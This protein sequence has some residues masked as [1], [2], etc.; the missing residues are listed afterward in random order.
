MRH[1]ETSGAATDDRFGER[2]TG[3]ALAL[4]LRL[5]D[6]PPGLLET[7]SILDRL[8][9]KARSGFMVRQLNR[10]ISPE[11]YILVAD[12]D[13]AVAELVSRIKGGGSTSGD[14]TQLLDIAARHSSTPEAAVAALHALRGSK[15]GNWCS[16]TTADTLAKHS[17]PAVLG[18]LADLVGANPHLYR[19]LCDRGPHAE[20]LHQRLHDSHMK[21][22]D[23]LCGDTR[24]AGMKETPTAS[25]S[26]HRASRPRA[27]G[28]VRLWSQDALETMSQLLAARTA[29]EDLA[30][31][32]EN[33][34]TQL[35]RWQATLARA[36]H[37]PAVTVT[38]LLTDPL[39]EHR[40][41]SSAGPHQHTTTLR[42][43]DAALAALHP[44]SEPEG[45]WLNANQLRAQVYADLAFLLAVDGAQANDAL[46]IWEQMA[47]HDRQARRVPLAQLSHS[48]RQRVWAAAWGG[49]AASDLNPDRPWPAWCPWPKDETLLALEAASLSHGLPHPNPSGWLAEQLACRLDDS[50]ALDDAYR[51][52]LTLSATWSGN[53]GHLLD[54]C[55]AAVRR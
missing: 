28:T 51:Q 25:M 20:L 53:L 3:D 41:S 14:L 30:T 16:D 42:G 22:Q 37:D 35:R 1:T 6:E 23:F 47:E 38:E 18:A 12:A 7:V 8:E 13:E 50:S 15:F 33:T 10:M 34:Y 2:L 52:T 46:P 29:T 9:G 17:D 26:W 32:G 24:G 45:E 55:A 43:G 27:G 48:S 40:S 11:N 54:A 4:H 31:R 5:R 21:Q 19:L 36:A 44:H 39:P 49:W